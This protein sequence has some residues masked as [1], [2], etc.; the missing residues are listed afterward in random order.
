[1]AFT[2]QDQWVLAFRMYAL[3]HMLDHLPTSSHLPE[4]AINEEMPIVVQLRQIAFDA[5]RARNL[6]EAMTTT[7]DTIAS[8]VVD[9][10]ELQISPAIDYDLL[11]DKVAER[12]RSLT[13]VLKPPE[14]P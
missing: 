3:A 14:T 13:F 9:I 7:I 11:A 1:M 10:H 12:L 8:I 6:L 5:A 4:S 2:E